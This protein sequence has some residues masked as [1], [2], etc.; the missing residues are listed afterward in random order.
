MIDTESLTDALRI[1]LPLRDA[2]NGD[3]R[4]DPQ[5]AHIGEARRDR[6]RDRETQITRG[7]ICVRQFER[8]N[9]ELRGRRNRRACCGGWRGLDGRSRRP[10]GCRGAAIHVPVDA[11]H[12]DRDDE[13][14]DD[15]E[16]E[17]AGRLCRDR[18]VALHLVLALQAFRCQLVHPGENQ[19]RQKPSTRPANR[20]SLVQ[21]GSFE[22]AE[23][24][25]GDLQQDPGRDEVQRCHSEDVS[26]FQL[27]DYG[28]PP[29]PRCPRRRRILR[30]SG[31][32]RL[33]I[34]AILAAPLARSCP[35]ADRG[36][37]HAAGHWTTVVTV[38]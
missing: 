6:I 1:G 27:R 35:S 26:T 37:L 31:L 23:Q 12:T 38:C 32:I 29:T 25:V 24:Q 36:T 14:S 4:P 20:S 19:R 10:F 17:L 7:F 9:R 18:G 33:I 8:K 2:Q 28:H 13:Q 11:K 22:H 5:R 16:V 34:R 30:P 21:A 3:R 15:D